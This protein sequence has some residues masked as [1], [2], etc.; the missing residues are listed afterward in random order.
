M[1]AE[2]YIYKYRPSCDRLRQFCMRHRVAYPVYDEGDAI[3]DWIQHYRSQYYSTRKII[4]K[5]R[6]KWFQ[7]ILI[8]SMIHTSEPDDF[9]QYE[10]FLRRSIEN[11]IRKGKSLRQ[12][13]MLLSHDFPQFREEIMILSHEYSDTEA[14]AHMQEKAWK[15]Y[16]TSTREGKW[17]YEQY[18]RERG[19]EL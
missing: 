1:N 7:P 12:I 14:L 9:S 8:D 5:L 13:R 3:S 15:K 19:F 16:D 17:K 11:H 4:E 18:L 10:I 6:I 2:T